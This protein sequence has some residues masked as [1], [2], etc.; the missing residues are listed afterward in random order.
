MARIDF[1]QKAVITDGKKILLVRKSSND[2]HNPGRWELPGGRMKE[3]E[4]V[5]QHI[6][7]EVREETGL[8]IKPGNVICLSDWTMTWHGEE[9]RVIAVS[10]WC[11]L[12]SSPVVAK[13]LEEDDYLSEQ[14]WFQT[15]ELA[16]L[17]VIP[18]QLATLERIL[19]DKENQSRSA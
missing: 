18:S 14:H 9:V 17:D 7:R 6:V 16:G 13:Q 2:P 12:T 8:T 4:D 10:R 11:E 5:D 3:M 1:A 15:S 19:K